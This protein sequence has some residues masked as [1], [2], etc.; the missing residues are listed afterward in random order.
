MG[1]GGRVEKQSAIGVHKKGT[2]GIYFDVH[3][4]EKGG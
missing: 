2:T 3:L 4:F 1:C